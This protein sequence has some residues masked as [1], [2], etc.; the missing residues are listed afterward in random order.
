MKTIKKMII[1]LLVAVMIG[2]I[3]FFAARHTDKKNA[4]EVRTLDIEGTIR[5]IGELATAEFG[6][7]ITQTV[8]KPSKLKITG[9]K[10]L[11]SYEGLIKAGIDFSAVDITV[12][13]AQKIIYIKMPKAIILSNELDHDSL[14]V[15]DSKYSIFST[16]TFEDINSSQANA[17]RTAEEEAV[18]SGLLDRAGANAKTIIEQTVMSLRESDEYQIKF[19]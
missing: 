10:V 15:Y 6:Y 18:N 17:K 4:P 3:G 7:T 5:D 9:S 14:K 12:N 13:K 8:D 19:Q 2:G 1:F 11:Y 16:L